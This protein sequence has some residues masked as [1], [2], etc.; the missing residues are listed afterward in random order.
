MLFS[1]VKLATT[2]LHTCWRYGMKEYFST[3]LKGRAFIA[4]E[5]QPNMPPFRYPINHRKNYWERDVRFFHAANYAYGIPKRMG[6][7]SV[8]FNEFVPQDKLITTWG[9]VLLRG[10]SAMITHPAQALGLDDS[11]RSSKQNLENYSRSHAAWTSTPPPF[12]HWHMRAWEAS[13]KTNR[14]LISMTGRNVW[15]GWFKYLLSCDVWVTTRDPNLWLM[16]VWFRN[17]V[18]FCEGPDSCMADPKTG[19]LIQGVISHESHADFYNGNVPGCSNNKLWCSEHLPLNEF[20]TITCPGC[21][22]EP[23]G[24]CAGDWSQTHLCNVP[25]KR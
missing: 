3:L 14:V 18:G 4:S 21:H 8:Y 10:M 25:F 17:K 16:G 24:M 5:P 19:F 7:K 12:Q 23:H 20:K 2:S 22:W 15:C 13:A 1:C 6:R 11:R 9:R